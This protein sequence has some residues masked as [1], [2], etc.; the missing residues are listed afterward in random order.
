[1]I[2]RRSIQ[3]NVTE[4]MGNKIETECKRLQIKPKDFYKMLLN[5]YFNSHPVQDTQPV[6]TV[7]I[8]KPHPED[9]MV[10]IG[11]MYFE[12][13]AYQKLENLFPSLVLKDV[14]E[15]MS[16]SSSFRLRSPAA[17]GTNYNDWLG[18]LAQ[19]LRKLTNTA[20]KSSLDILNE[21]QAKCLN[22][23]SKTP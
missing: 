17:W 6:Q 1:M 16:K 15:D 20:T 18:N 5:E 14:L 2:V 13:V 23:E 12:D 10:I 21:F 19:H 22:G 9:T 11:E 8:E 3:Y 7:E 4:E